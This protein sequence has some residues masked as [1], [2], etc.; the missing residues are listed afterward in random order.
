MS[1]E[2]EKYAVYWVPKRTDPLAR[3]GVCWTGWCAEQGEFRARSEFGSFS[4]DVAA[5]TRR[6]RRHGLH[7]VIKAP[8]RLGTGRSRFTL[9][10]VLGQLV[11]DSVSFQLPRLELAVVDGRVALVPRQNCPALSDMVASIGDAVAPLDAAGSA[12]GF[13]ESAVLSPALEGIVVED[14][15]PLVQLPAADTHRFHMPLTDPL[16]IE[17]AFK[18]MAE[19]KPLLEPML[20]DPRALDDIALMGDPGQG[21]PLRVLQRYDLSDTPRR[22]T[23]RAMPCQGPHVLVPML[24]DRFA[25]SKIAI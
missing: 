19:L 10:H 5:I 8:F 11:D 13:A 15:E 1:D 9:E 22:Q 7:A 20:D 23:S 3:F 14:A 25:K 24:D 12:N 16:G 2:F 18:V 21:R 17:L 6:L 4:F